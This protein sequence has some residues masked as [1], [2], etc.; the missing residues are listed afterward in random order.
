MGK[1]QIYDPVLDEWILG[2]DMPYAGGSVATALIGD[3][4]YVAGGIVGSATVTTAAMYDPATDS[5]SILPSMPEGVNHAAA[6]TDGQKFY[7]FGGRD[8]KN[9]VSNGFNYVQIYDPATNSWQSSNDPG[10]TLAPLPQ[11][12]GG[13]GKAVYV[14]GEFYVIGGE[15]ATGAGATANKVYDRVDIYNP[16]TNSWRPGPA[17]TTARHGIFPVAIGNR[18]YVAGGGAKAGAAESTIFEI[19]N[20]EEGLSDPSPTPTHTPTRTPTSTSTPCCVATSTSSATN[21]AISTATV[22]ST[23]LSSTPTST[24]TLSSTPTSTATLSSTPTST[25]TIPINA[26]TRPS[27]V[28]CPPTSTPTSRPDDE[29]TIFL[30]LIAR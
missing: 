26:T 7:I 11:A 28:C 16:R 10:A 13:M 21:T 30:P 23:A 6:A 12:R 4:V 18:I 29:N 3:K 19:Y 1:V 27:A 5:W 14:A 2:A 9:E 15:T 22:S 20:L 8:G 24:A 25:T 17:M